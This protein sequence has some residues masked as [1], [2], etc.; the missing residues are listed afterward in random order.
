[1]PSEIKSLLDMG[2]AVGA[3]SEV[4]AM[5]SDGEL[6]KHESATPC[7]STMEQPLQHVAAQTKH[8]PPRVAASTITPI[9]IVE[10]SMPP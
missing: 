5:S 6:G 8:R 9:A 2:F 7:T 1:M 3:R 4:V 10:V